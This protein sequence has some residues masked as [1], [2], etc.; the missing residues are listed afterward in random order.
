MYALLAITGRGRVGGAT[1]RDI[2]TYGAF[3][4]Q[5]VHTRVRTPR[6]VYA[7]FLARYGSG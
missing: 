2:R 7:L 6:S 5:T 1:D 3:S 4:D